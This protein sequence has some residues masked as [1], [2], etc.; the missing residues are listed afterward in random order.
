M[1]VEGA[2]TFLVEETLAPT[3]VESHVPERTQ[4]RGELRR[5]S[6]REEDNGFFFVP[7]PRRNQERTKPEFLKG[8]LQ[9]LLAT[10]RREARD[11]TLKFFF[12]FSFLFFF[13]SLKE[14]SVFRR[15]FFPASRRKHDGRRGRSEGATEAE[16]RLFDAVIKREEAHDQFAKP[17]WHLHAPRTAPR[18]R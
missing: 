6:V 14:D 11:W 16:S 4:R 5:T 9:S 7:S 15:G 12:C 1:V 17:L 2:G 18:R 13:F 8:G 10:R 3:V